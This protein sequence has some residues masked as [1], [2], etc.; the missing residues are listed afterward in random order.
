MERDSANDP[1]LAA[2]LRDE[3]AMLDR[4]FGSEPYEIDEEG[5]IDSSRLRI[6]FSMASGDGSLTVMISAPSLPGRLGEE[7]SLLQWLR[8]FGKDEKGALSGDKLGGFSVHEALHRLSTL[9]IASLHDPSTLLE[10]AA[11]TAGYVQGIRDYLDERGW[12]TADRLGK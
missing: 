9:P 2:R 5:N 8:Y 7:Y 3:K 10:A 1:T 6:S 4:I 12:W 11:F